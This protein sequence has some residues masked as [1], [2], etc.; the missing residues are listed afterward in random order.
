MR[1]RDSEESR[2]WLTGVTLAAV[3]IVGASLVASLAWNRMTNSRIQGDHVDWK[4][5]AGL[6]DLGIR[7]GDA[8]AHLGSADT[9][10]WARLANVRIVAEIPGNVGE[11]D[12]WSQTAQG[13]ADALR[14][15]E[16]TGAKAVVA[17]WRR[18]KPASAMTEGWQRITDRDV[19]VYLFDKGSATR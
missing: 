2:R 16:R 19:Y 14:A 11:T 15:I 8:V 13:R 1:F 9:L 6:A 17:G 5:A 18:K 4:I 3:A 7:P 12:F 10:Y